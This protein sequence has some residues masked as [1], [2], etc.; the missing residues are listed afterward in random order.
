MRDLAPS[1]GLATPLSA[2][3]LAAQ[4]TC[5]TWEDYRAS[6]ANLHTFVYVRRLE[7]AGQ[8]S[9]PWRRWGLRLTSPPAANATSARG[10]P[11]ATE[12]G[13]PSSALALRGRNCWSRARRLTV[14]DHAGWDLLAQGGF[15]GLGRHWPAEEKPLREFAAVLA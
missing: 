5:R 1:R 2:A 12:I 15:E 13:V 14:N 9:R 6:N 10:P 3:D 11:A 8:P 7:A 4:G